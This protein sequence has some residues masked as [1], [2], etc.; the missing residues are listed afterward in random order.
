MELPY[1]LKTLEPLQGALDI[2]RYLGTL[3][4]PTA[5]ADEICDALD[6]SS[7]RFGKAIRRLVTQSYVV[8]DGAMTYR[9]AERGHKAVEILA[10]YDAANPASDA[11]ADE[12]AVD[13][14]LRHLVVALPQPLVAQAANTVV[15][16]VEGAS[17]GGALNV[18]A[19]LVLR[20]SVVNGQPSKPVEA[21]L[22]LGNEPAQH[23]FSVTPDAYQ[24][25]RLRVQVFQLGP[26]PDDINIA[27]GLYI[28]ADVTGAAHNPQ[29]VAYGG[30]LAVQMLE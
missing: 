3:D 7:V 28:D 2:L 29:F 24:Q 13:S 11:N 26:N 20:L 15:V 18:P 30:T 4:V 19:D 23:S 5:D 8:M 27:G 25:V 9:L 21:G 6:I 12:G 16:G 10:A 14:V 22:T 1:D 17:S